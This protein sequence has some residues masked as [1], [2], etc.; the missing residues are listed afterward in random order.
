MPAFP[1]WRSPD[2]TTSATEAAD[3]QL[4]LTT[5]LST[6]KR[7][8][9][10]GENCAKTAEMIEMLFDVWTWV[11]PSTYALD[12][13]ARWRHLVNSLQLISVD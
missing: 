12:G 7:V 6:P 8:I 5:H 13:G 10:K 4:Q 1:S 2:V 3:I 11:H 9:S